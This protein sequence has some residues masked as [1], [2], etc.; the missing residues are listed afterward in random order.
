MHDSIVHAWNFRFSACTV[1][2]ML[3]PPLHYTTF[4]LRW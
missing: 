4:E 1:L 2:F 3:T